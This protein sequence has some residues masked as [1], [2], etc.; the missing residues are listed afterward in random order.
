[1]VFPS[2]REPIFLIQVRK[3]DLRPL[4]NALGEEL[5]TQVKE[6]TE[7][8]PELDRST[9]P[10]LI[11]PS[12]SALIE[13]LALRFRGRMLLCASTRK[14]RTDYEPS[15][16]FF[17]LPI[18]T[19]FL[20]HTLLLQLKL[21]AQQGKTLQLHH[22][23]QCLQTNAGV[24]LPSLNLK[25]GRAFLIRKALDESHDQYT[26]AAKLLGISR[27]ALSQDLKRNDLHLGPFEPSQSNIS[28]KKRS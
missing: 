25:L 18:H 24:T 27:Q 6:T 4:Y 13:R 2:F 3:T 11:Y 5:S 17:R 28:A 16:L 23:L 8:N 19:H 26:Q 9:G 15:C 7:R 21:L 12:D 20:R 14:P 10:I 1:M 22:R